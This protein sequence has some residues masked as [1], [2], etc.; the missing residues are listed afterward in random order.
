MIY[1]RSQTWTFCPELFKALA[2]YS[3]GT[4]HPVEISPEQCMNTP[5]FKAHA[6]LRPHPDQVQMGLGLFSSLRRNRK[7][8]NLRMPFS[9]S[10]MPRH[11]GS[12]WRES[13]PRQ[14]TTNKAPSEPPARQEG[15][16]HSS[17]FCS[18]FCSGPQWSAQSHWR[19]HQVYPFC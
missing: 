11:E 16:T 6:A 12:G 19:G 17:F 14:G 9:P 18:Q 8:R 5:S 15:R 2:F 10:R 7:P 1:Y 4:A 3:W 13:Q